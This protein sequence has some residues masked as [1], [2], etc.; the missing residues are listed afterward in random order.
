MITN[1]N[2]GAVA[3]GNIDLIDT[4]SNGIV[5]CAP[6]TEELITQHK[7]EDTVVSFINGLYSDTGS[8][9]SICNESLL[10]SPSTAMLKPALYNLSMALLYARDGKANS[11]LSL[12]IMEG[13][14]EH[15][16][17]PALEMLNAS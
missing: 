13:L 11:R 1:N 8:E 5:L 9:E 14:A 17:E 4:K 16:F 10:W 12:H 7:M 3:L 2:S 15:G 6:V